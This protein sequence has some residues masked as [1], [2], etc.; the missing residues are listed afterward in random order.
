[1]AQVSL[2]YEECAALRE[3]A[4][5]VPPGK[6]S[7]S[8]ASALRTLAAVTAAVERGRAMLDREDDTPI[9]GRSSS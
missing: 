9:P 4:E 2:S 6:R 8:L 3:A 5:K 7:R 1:M